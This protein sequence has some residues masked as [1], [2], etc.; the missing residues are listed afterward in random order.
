MS[1]F[2]V[3]KAKKMASKFL[4]IKKLACF[5]LQLERGWGSILLDDLLPHLGIKINQGEGVCVGV[6]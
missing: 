3:D 2:F 1:K 6:G 4:K 5:F